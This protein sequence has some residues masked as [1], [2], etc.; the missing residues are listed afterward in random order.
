MKNNRRRVNRSPKHAGSSCAQFALLLGFKRAGD[1][2]DGSCEAIKSYPAG[3]QHCCTLGGK[4]RP[5]KSIYANRRLIIY[6]L[7]S[8]CFRWT[9]TARG[10]ITNVTARIGAQARGGKVFISK[11]TADRIKDHF[12]LSPLGKFNLKNVSEEV[13]IYE[14]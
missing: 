3:N 12:S 4:N 14:I 1:E 8:P 11:S 7:M 5:R 9:Y 10:G 2:H 6:I 13:E